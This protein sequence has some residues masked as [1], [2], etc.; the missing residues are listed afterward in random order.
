[1]PLF[2]SNFLVPFSSKNTKKKYWSSYSHICLNSLQSRRFYKSLEWVSFQTK[3]IQ[4]KIQQ[5]I[6]SNTEMESFLWFRI[7]LQTSLYNVFKFASK[8]T[9]RGIKSVQF[10]KLC[11]DYCKNKTIRTCIIHTSDHYFHSNK[12]QFKF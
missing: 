12:A 4:N 7:D 8:S 5:C 1:M 9:G 2:E 11:L 10:W 3:N 6:K